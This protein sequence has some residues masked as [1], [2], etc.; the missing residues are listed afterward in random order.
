MILMNSINMLCKEY[1]YL[2]E[3]LAVGHFCVNVYAVITKKN[4]TKF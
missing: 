2:S 3:Y 4:K 1:D